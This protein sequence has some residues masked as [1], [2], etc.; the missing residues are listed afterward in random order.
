MTKVSNL[1]NDAGLRFLLRR[2]D[3]APRVST[4]S[5]SALE[6]RILAKVDGVVRVGSPSEGLA[7]V[8]FSRQVALFFQE[9]SSRTAAFAAVL[10][11]VLGVG[12]GQH[13]ACPL[14]A[15][16]SLLVLAD[17]AL[18]SPLSEIDLAAEDSDDIVQ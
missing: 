17:E 5:L 14:F 12:V 13:I 16:P 4:E 9:R 18:W 1:E 10:V 11:L 7:F 15:N 3:P 2:Y 8:D 6:A